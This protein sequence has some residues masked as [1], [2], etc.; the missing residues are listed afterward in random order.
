[1]QRLQSIDNRVSNVGLNIFHKL[2]SEM[3]LMKTLHLSRYLVIIFLIL[4]FSF[5]FI[6][7]DTIYIFFWSTH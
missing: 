6:E 2:S 5:V 4:L 3:I 7:M 1:M